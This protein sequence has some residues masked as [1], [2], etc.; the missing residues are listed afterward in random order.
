MSQNGHKNG[1]EGMS[2]GHTANK[3]KK[4]EIRDGKDKSVEVRR[5]GERDLQRD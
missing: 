1:V 2:V 3:R 5:E 4:G